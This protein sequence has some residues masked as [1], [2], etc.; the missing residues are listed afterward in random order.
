MVNF[1]STAY[2][3]LRNSKFR[4]HLFKILLGVRPSS[5]EILHDLIGEHKVVQLSD[6]GIHDFLA[7]AFP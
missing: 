7:R 2:L 1:M 5:L 6:S 3:T 4:I